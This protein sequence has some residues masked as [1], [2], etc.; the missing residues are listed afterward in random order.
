MNFLAKYGK[1]YA[2][3]EQFAERELIFAGNYYKVMNHNMMLAADEGYTM[4]LN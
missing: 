4:A 2:T 1:N 3:Y